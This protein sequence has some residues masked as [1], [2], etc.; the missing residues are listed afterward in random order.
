M[1]RRIPCLLVT[2]TM[3]LC[4]A[5]CGGQNVPT[6]FSLS[7][8]NHFSKPGQ[9]FITYTVVTRAGGN[10][11]FVYFMVVKPPEPANGMRHQSSSGQSSAI[12]LNGQAKSEITLNGKK[13]TVEYTMTVRTDSTL[14]TESFIVSGKKQAFEKGRIFLVDLSTEPIRIVQHDTKLSDTIPDLRNPAA[15]DSLAVSTLDELEKDPAIA[16]FTRPLR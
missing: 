6:S 12:G 8:P 9:P 5:G 7:G 4:L 13:L 15:N 3:M 2:G 10:R 11:E 1:I 16:E 14:D